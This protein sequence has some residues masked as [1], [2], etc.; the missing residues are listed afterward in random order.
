V[1]ETSEA[2]P[3]S[4]VLWWVA[5]SALTVVLVIV[6]ARTFDVVNAP[7]SGDRGLFLAIAQEILRGGFPHESTFDHK[8][9]GYPIAAAAAMAAGR[10]VGLDDVLADRCLNMAGLAV[11]MVL[12]GF[13]VRRL[14]GSAAAVLVS[15]AAVGSS[16]VLAVSSV[17]GGEP[18]IPMLV[19]GMVS[20][21]M[22]TAHRPGAGGVAAGLSSLFWQPGALFLLGALADGDRQPHARHPWTIALTGFAAPWLVVI[23]LFAVRGTLTRFLTEVLAF[24]LSYVSRQLPVG[25]FGTHLQRLVATLS[26]WDLGLLILGTIGWSFV[27]L[28]RPGSGCR[29]RTARG[30]AAVFG[31][32]AILS[33]VN[34]QGPSD[35]LPLQTLAAIG[36]GCGAAAVADDRL[37]RAAPAIVAVALTALGVR[38]FCLSAWT[39]PPRLEDQRSAVAP[40]ADHVRST[41]RPV[42]CAGV[43]APLVLGD[44]A[45]ATPYTY[46]HSEAH[47]L[48]ES[49]EGMPLWRF[50]HDQA[51]NRG[52][53]VIIDRLPWEVRRRV[54]SQLETAIPRVVLRRGADLGL[55][56]RP[57]ALVVFRPPDSVAGESPRPSE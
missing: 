12:S 4:S 17:L 20:L 23:G 49:R 41:G 18:K 55:G 45:N 43:P 6:H 29:P 31:T 1:H 14:G 37:R 19:M 22:F 10:A 32:F 21:A 11:L 16:R 56:W 34:H 28:G 40:I 8:P 24:N 36:V 47:R 57:D 44:L 25:D 5:A 13:L 48:L 3:G 52:T 50:I 42:W 53:L 30:P 51:A 15:I 46:L 26:P 2:T 33:L 35:H 54:E 9:P 27:L 7:L 39:G 38:V